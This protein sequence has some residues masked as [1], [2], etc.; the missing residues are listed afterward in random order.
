MS[1]GLRY[2]KKIAVAFHPFDKTA[3]GARE[4]FRQVSA[5][6]SVATNPK[7]TL[8]A[9]VLERQEGPTVDIELKNGEKITFDPASDL[10]VDD[11]MGQLLNRTT[12]LHMKEMSK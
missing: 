3:R 6:P 4:F 2:V 12:A 11:I 1:G 10:L 9:T 8:K 5:G 7:V